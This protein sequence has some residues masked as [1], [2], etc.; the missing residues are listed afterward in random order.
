M[1][2]T[3]ETG[4]MKREVERKYILRTIIGKRKSCKY[5]DQIGR[6]GNVIYKVK[7][8]LFYFLKPFGRLL[9]VIGSRFSPR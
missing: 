7:G 2:L 8:D 6:R 5:Y 4:K 3:G 9:L 1:G